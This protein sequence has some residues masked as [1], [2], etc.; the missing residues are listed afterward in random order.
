MFDRWF[1]LTLEGTD[2]TMS[3]DPFVMEICQESPRTTLENADALSQR[4]EEWGDRELCYLTGAVDL[5]GLNRIYTI[6]A[7]H[8]EV[9]YELEVLL[10]D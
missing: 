4:S 6:L 7:Q 3:N 8:P 2:E 10:L 5:E 9:T 1:K